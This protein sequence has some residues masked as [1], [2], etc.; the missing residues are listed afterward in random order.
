MQ[1]GIKGLTLQI[2]VIFNYC[3]SSLSRPLHHL[4]MYIFVIVFL[5]CCY[6]YMCFLVMRHACDVISFVTCIVKMSVY[7]NV[8]GYLPHCV[9]ILLLSKILDKDMIAL[10][11]P[12][13]L[14]GKWEVALLTPHYSPTPAAHYTTCGNQ[15]SV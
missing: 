7:I 10:F 5:F 13:H 11:S 6:V 4:E 2:R 1:C 9:I 15:I 8:Y 12:C 3:T 14:V